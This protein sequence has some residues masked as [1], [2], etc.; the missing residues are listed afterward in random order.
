MK[1]LQQKLAD[2]DTI[3]SPLNVK[4]YIAR[5]ICVSN[6]SKSVYGFHYFLRDGDQ[7]HTSKSKNYARNMIKVAFNKIDIF[8]ISLVGFSE[9]CEISC[10]NV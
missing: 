10:K 8:K 9:K 2:S 3:R 7:R 1:I 5:L 4:W 6:E